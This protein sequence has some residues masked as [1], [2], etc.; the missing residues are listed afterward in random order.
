[1]PRFSAAHLHA[2]TCRLTAYPTSH[3]CDR[4]RAQW[5]RSQPL[6]PL[7]SDPWLLSPPRPRHLQGPEEL[8]PRKVEPVVLMGGP[9]RKPSMC[10]RLLFWKFEDSNCFKRELNSRDLI[11]FKM[12]LWEL[13]KCWPSFRRQTS[14]FSYF[15]HLEL[16]WITITQHFIYWDL[17][18]STVT[19]SLSGA[20]LWLAA[21]F[22]WMSQSHSCILPLSLDRH[23][24]KCHYLF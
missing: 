2:H 5:E 7:T 12:S 17:N 1:M 19:G 24:K 21:V 8:F 22:I 16:I 4:C 23:I 11:L 6:K 13:K 20:S 15:I 3:M 9:W 14:K 10:R 18:R